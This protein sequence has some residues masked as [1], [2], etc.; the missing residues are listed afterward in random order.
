MKHNVKYNF[1]S[2]QYT[3]ILPYSVNKNM[4]LYMLK[5]IKL[6]CENAIVVFELHFTKMH[7]KLQ[8]AIV[9]KKVM[10]KILI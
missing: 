8:L 1:S 2:Y 5:R 10:E 6:I 3:L 7:W 9:G 4:S